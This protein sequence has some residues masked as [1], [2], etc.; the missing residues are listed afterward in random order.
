MNRR[1]RRQVSFLIS[2]LIFAALAVFAYR[3]TV[4]HCPLN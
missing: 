2:V 1:R 3:T 4:G